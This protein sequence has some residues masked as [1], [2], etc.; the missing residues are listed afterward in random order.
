MPGTTPQKNNHDWAVGFLF[1]L[2]SMR[3]IVGVS[4]EIRGRLIHYKSGGALSSEALR[5]GARRAIGLP[6]MCSRY[7]RRQL[8]GL[9]PCVATRSFRAGEKN[10][11]TSNPF[12]KEVRERD[13]KRIRRPRIPATDELLRNRFSVGT[14]Y[15]Y[16]SIVSFAC[17]ANAAQPC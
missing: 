7:A 11:G 8:T 10:T 4:V 15:L 13:W 9:H 17:G 1:I 3:R 16:A 5:P 14:I 2:Q 12:Q 6:R